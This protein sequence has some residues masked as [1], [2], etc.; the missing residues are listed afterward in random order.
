MCVF[1]RIQTKEKK[2]I[3][4]KDHKNEKKIELIKSNTR[5]AN[6]KSMDRQIKT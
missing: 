1:V 5:K 3:R 2:R 6:N 4:P